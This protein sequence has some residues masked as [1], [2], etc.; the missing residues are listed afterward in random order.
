MET[1]TD[2]GTVLCRGC[3][4]TGLVSVLD[5]GRQALSNEMALSQEGV[6]ATFP[7]HL[8]VCPECGLGQL[9]EFVLPERIFSR[10][11]PYQSSVSTSWLAHAGRYVTR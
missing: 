7:L 9:G 6:D 11:Y 2:R 10:D 3:G 1:L 5:L 8:R 4:V